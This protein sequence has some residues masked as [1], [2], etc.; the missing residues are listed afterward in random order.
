MLGVILE[1]NNSTATAK[2]AEGDGGG[3]FF[4]PKMDNFKPYQISH[5]PVAF[6]GNLNKCLKIKTQEIRNDNS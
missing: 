5:V 3:T 4:H 2:F 6:S 1:A